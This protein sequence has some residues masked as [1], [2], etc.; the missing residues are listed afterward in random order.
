MKY[1]THLKILVI[2]FPLLAA[3]ASGHDAV[4]KNA[5][6]V[7]SP[8]ISSPSPSIS[9]VTPSPTYTL[10]PSAA[11]ISTP[12]AVAAPSIP[13]LNL[14]MGDISGSDIIQ[15][16]V[17]KEDYA[18][19]VAG[20]VG[21]RILN[22]S[23]PEKP[24]QVGQYDTNGYAL[25][26][27]VGG[28]YVYIADELYG[29]RVIDVTDPTQPAEVGFYDTA[30]VTRQVVLADSYA[31][32][33]GDG[34]LRIV[35]VTDP[36]N[37][38]EVG[39]HQESGWASQV[40]VAGQV[41]YLVNQGEGVL[42]VDVS[43]PTQPD[44]VGQYP[45]T[46]DI[47]QMVI[48]PP[49][50]YLVLKGG[51][52]RVVNISDPQYPLEVADYE[53]ESCACPNYDGLIV[54]NGTVY[55]SSC[56]GLLQ[57]EVSPQGE[58]NIV[59]SYELDW[60]IYALQL[61]G[62]TMYGYREIKGTPYLLMLPD[63]PKMLATATT[64]ST[65]TPSPSAT[66]TPA[67]SPTPTVT[68]VKLATPFPPTP[69][70]A[71]RPPYAHNLELIGH[72]GGE[73]VATATDNTYLYVGFG[74]ELAIMSVAS[75]TDPQRI[76]YLVLPEIIKRLYINDN[77]AYVSDVRDNLWVIDVSDP[78]TPEIVGS[79]DDQD[80]LNLSGP[81]RIM[82]MILRGNYLYL[83]TQSRGLVVADISDPTQPTEVAQLQGPGWWDIDGI[84][85]KGN[86][87]FVATTHGDGLGVI[88]IS[89]PL[90][91]KSVA[92]LG[93]GWGGTSYRN[94]K[95]LTIIDDY[96][97]VDQGQQSR[98]FDLSSPTQPLLVKDVPTQLEWY[99]PAL[100]GYVYQPNKMGNLQ[101]LKLSTSGSPEEVTVY[102]S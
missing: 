53:P 85:V 102:K 28:D 59:Q 66:V 15:D 44:T 93:D 98:I 13:S 100:A 86:Y 89:D 92:S 81:S 69:R 52:V 96:L 9:T 61:D 73:V 42:V 41:G 68:S 40:V 80:N 6:F 78:L 18:Y 57:L 47:E 79:L 21:L 76:G 46:E 99:R 14:L 17:V 83:A 62:D 77:Y 49:Y 75:P 16:I 97:Y 34:D 4:S 67:S 95:H 74:P 84:V 5:K 39:I 55:A 72:I 10:I 71:S 60:I 25:G 54:L 43:N 38:V 101:I 45:L 48:A 87:A 37:P 33:L 70:H 35:D 51:G 90:S 50:L 11:P 1:L 31:Y 36:M 12:S 63:L 19:I 94:R 82:D 91:P 7:S 56:P 30:H 24:T 88:D 8:T 29:M 20:H 65:P 23:N 3:C 22:I 27:A 32:L 58:L 64:A 26:V 2:I